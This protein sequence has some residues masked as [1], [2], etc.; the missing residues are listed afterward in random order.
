[1]QKDPIDAV[2]WENLL[3]QR[4]NGDQK[5]I[6]QSIIELIQND[7]EPLSKRL[8]KALSLVENAK[9]TTLN[10]LDFG[11][12][13][14]FR[15]HIFVLVGATGVGKSVLIDRLL[16]FF[17]QD[18]KSIVVLA[19]DPTSTLSGG[20]LLGDRIRLSHSPQEEAVFY[21]SVASRGSNKAFSESIPAMI[22]VLSLFQIDVVIVETMGVAQQDSSASQIADTLVN[23]L[24][25]S[26]GDEI[27][28]YKSGILEFGDIYFVNKTDIDN[29]ESIFSLLQMKF[30][31]N[32]V[33][34]EHLLP[35][36]L[37]GSAADKIGID[38]LYFS[39]LSHMRNSAA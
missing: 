18:F 32:Q 25:P 7:F 27:Q 31:G 30:G 19:T 24:G 34:Q 38:E 11:V 2:L 23:V 12:L 39:M 26:S 13:L 28:L 33:N 14:G 20:A 6:Q 17:L 36:V 16:P 3:M 8:G 21:R 15:P 5:G 29:S 10:S 1:M 22:N 37:R 9:V 35:K 4:G